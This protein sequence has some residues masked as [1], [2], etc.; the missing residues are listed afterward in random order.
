MMKRR[1]S[2]V[3]LVVSLG[4]MMFPVSVQ[5]SACVASDQRICR[6]ARQLEAYASGHVVAYEEVEDGQI[7]GR[8]ETEWMPGG[9]DV[10]R[11]ANPNQ[12]SESDLMFLLGHEYGHSI[13]RHSR[14]D[15][16]RVALDADKGLDD[17]ALFAK[18]GDHDSP[19]EVSHQQELAADA[20]AI[21]FMHA[22][23]R[24]ALPVIRRVL[25]SSRES[26]THPSKAARI[27][28]AESRLLSLTSREAGASASSGTESKIEEVAH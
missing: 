10:I 27:K 23:K 18:Y 4:S 21:R 22:M 1:L 25:G 2:V 24:N 15:V 6:I 17:A 3:A 12:Y 14:L 7:K 5:A 19:A 16:E 13:L 20:F 9:V 26:E 11:I 8:A 28:S